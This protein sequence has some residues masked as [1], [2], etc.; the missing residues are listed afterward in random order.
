MIEDRFGIKEVPAGWCFLPVSNG[1]LQ[2]VNSREKPFLD[3]EVKLLDSVLNQ[4]SV[5]N[6]CANGSGGARGDDAVLS[7]SYDIGQAVQIL[8]GAV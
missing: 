5:P 4:E 3:L 8:E 2:V 1:G 6:G 7:L